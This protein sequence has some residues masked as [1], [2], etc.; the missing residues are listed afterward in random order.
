MRDRTIAIKRNGRC[1]VYAPK[2]SGDDL[3]LEQ[4]VG[5]GA[6]IEGPDVLRLQEAINR[7]PRQ[8]GGPARRLPESGRAGKAT[9]RAIEA[10]QERYFA[11]ADGRVEPMSKLHARICSLQPAQIERMREA[12]QVLTQSMTTM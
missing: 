1:S 3:A 12:R 6:A 5:K 11:S 7:I 2:P 8:Y 9:I 4:A 10:L